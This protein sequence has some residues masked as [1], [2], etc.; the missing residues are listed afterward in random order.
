MYAQL[1]AIA[2]RYLQGQRDHTLQPTALVN[3]AY[4][5]LDGRD[6]ASFENRE[7]FMAVAARAMRQIL[8]DHARRKTAEKRGGGAIRTTLSKLSVDDQDKAMDVLAIDEALTRLSELNPRHAQVV[9]LKFFGGM[10]T[11]ELA[12]ALDVS[13]ATVERDWMKARAWLLVQMGDEA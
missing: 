4:L 6:T 5:K 12:R 10:T 3:E 8:V 9:E 1:R 11:P 7:H 2:G 13:V